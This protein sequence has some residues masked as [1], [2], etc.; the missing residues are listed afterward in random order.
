[1]RKL[2]KRP[3]LA[4]PYLPNSPG[5][6]ERHTAHSAE[7]GDGMV[8]VDVGEPKGLLRDVLRSTLPDNE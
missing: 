2:R 7:V 3:P 4:N 6:T 1:M 5:Y 8:R